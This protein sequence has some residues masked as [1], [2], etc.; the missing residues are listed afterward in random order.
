MKRAS[1]A[2][3]GSQSPGPGGAFS[4]SSHEECRSSRFLEKARPE[5]FMDTM[6]FTPIELGPV[7]I[8][9]RIAVPPMCMYSA[10]SGVAQLFHKMHYGHLAA[11]GAGL[12]C[13]EAMAVTPEGRI[14]ESDLGLWSD[15]CEAGL[16]ELVDLMHEIEPACRVMVQ[17]NHAG[18]KASVTKP[19]DGETRTVEPMD[20]GWPVRAPSAIP[21]NERYT[22]PRVLS[23]DDCSRVAN[24]FGEAAKRAERAGVDGIE[25]HMA[26]G[27]L[28]HQFLS[29]LTNTRID[30]Y[31]GALE[32][33]MRF[34]R[35]VMNAVKSSVSDKVA[36]GLR[37]S[38]TDW[39]P[40]GWTIEDTVKL[41][42]VA[43]TQ[44]LHFVDVSTGGNIENAPIPV[45]PGYQVPFAS[46]V[47]AETGMP[48]FAVGLI[49]D[50]WQAETLLREGA[51]DV[52]DIG[53]AMLDDPH[54]GWHA[55]S[56]LHVKQV[57]ELVVPPQ[58]LRGLT[59]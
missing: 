25:I 27:Y 10:K 39:V 49:R 47:K 44:G 13:I 55:A 24:A 29:P 33:R 43:K 21:F 20:G 45:G 12:V 35:E 51:A 19:W 3:G 23:F 53:R 46:R 42:K 38:A 4:F 48:T 6:L 57:P 8:P 9:N 26:H 41:V 7:T 17:L 52:I 14:T 22:K 36:V 54:W 59:Y 37:V 2:A 50:A 16:K 40:D 31:G 32:N 11:S 18:R 56:A 30:E 1:G 58:Y 28:I 34:A 15:E 5:R